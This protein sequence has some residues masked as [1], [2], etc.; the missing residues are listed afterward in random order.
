MKRYNKYN[1]NDFIEF[2]KECKEDILFEH[3]F[4]VDLKGNYYH[5]ACYHLLNDLPSPEL[6]TEDDDE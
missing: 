6:I 4:V 3:G 5:L 1:K 2:C